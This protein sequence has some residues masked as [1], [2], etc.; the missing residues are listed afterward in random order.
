LRGERTSR[1]ILPRGWVSF[2]A[3]SDIV[4][5]GLGG[6]ATRV[7]LPGPQGPGGCVKPRLLR[8]PLPQ[9][10]DEHRSEYPILLAVDQKFG[11]CAT[12]RVAPEL[13]D[14]VGPIE[15][16]EHQ[17]VEQLGAVCSVGT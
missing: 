1:S 13:A 12:L 5:G 2:P 14:P 16:G 3:I 4:A 8:S 9:H 15:V 17:D 11:E 7:S 6:I 10:A